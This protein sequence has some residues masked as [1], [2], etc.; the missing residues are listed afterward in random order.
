MAPQSCDTLLNDAISRYVLNV[1]EQ[2]TA[3][4]R[5]FGVDTVRE[6]LCNAA[7]AGYVS[8]RRDKSKAITGLHEPIVDEALYDRVQDMRRERVRTLKPGRPSNRYLLRGI[9]RCERCQGKMHG[10]SVGRKLVP[11]YYCSTRRAEHTRDQPLVHTDVV[12]AELVEFIADFKPAPGIREEILRRLAGT[13]TADTADTVKRRSSLEER[14]ARAIS[15]SLAT[16]PVPSTW[17]AARQSTQSLPNSPPAPSPTSTRPAR[18]SRTSR[19]SGPERQTPPPSASSSRSSSSAY[20]W[21]SSVS[22]PSNRS[23][24]SPPISKPSR[25]KRRFRG[26]VKS[27]SDGGSN[28]RLSPRRSR[29]NVALAAGFRGPSTGSWRPVICPVVHWSSSSVL[30]RPASARAPT[31]LNATRS[32]GSASLSAPFNARSAS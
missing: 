20:G 14:L 9:A 19:S 12:E 13:A 24:P 8:G 2:R 32:S 4:D 23:H 15:M 6:M 29:W 3:R 28:P 1:N 26:C 5:A 7:Y 16:S 30:R 22:S 31:R 21:T 27:G 18:C 10:T 11:R 17:P 25:K